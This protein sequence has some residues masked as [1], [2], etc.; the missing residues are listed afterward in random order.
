MFQPLPS[1]TFDELAVLV[2]LGLHI[3]GLLVVEVPLLPQLVEHLVVLAVDCLEVYNA[4]GSTFDFLLE[5][6]AH[7]VVQLCAFGQQLAGEGLVEGLQLS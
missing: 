5:E 3:A 1:A 4:V 6:L 7:V 2:L